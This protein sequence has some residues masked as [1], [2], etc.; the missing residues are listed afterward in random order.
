[1][2]EITLSEIKSVDNAKL[3]YLVAHSITLALIGIL[4]ASIIFIAIKKGLITDQ[5][6]K[7]YSS[8]VIG[9]IFIV[10]LL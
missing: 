9:L 7:F 5:K 8:I 6:L 10:T 2:K 1:L 3:T 4:T